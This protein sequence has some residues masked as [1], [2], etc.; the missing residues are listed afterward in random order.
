MA[1]ILVLAFRCDRCG[2]VWASKRLIEVEIHAISAHSKTDSLQEH[3]SQREE[4][5]DPKMCPRC[6]TRLWD[7]PTERAEPIKRLVSKPWD[8]AD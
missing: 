2:H 4:H 5:S 3:L 7:V 1:R 6:K 8:P